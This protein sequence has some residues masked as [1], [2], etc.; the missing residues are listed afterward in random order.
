[1]AQEAASLIEPQHSKLSVAGADIDVPT[2]HVIER[3]WLR[4]RGRVSDLGNPLPW[5]RDVLSGSVALL[6]AFGIAYIT[7]L[8]IYAALGATNQLRFAWIGPLLLWGAIS[9]V[10]IA[11]LSYLMHSAVE[12]RLRANVG[13][14]L[15]EMDDIHAPPQRV[16]ALRMSRRE[17][18]VRKLFRAHEP[19]QSVTK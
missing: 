17:R 14:V 16:L 12:D 10:V 15:R 1:M 19:S 11:V 8:P 6:V 7:W 5:A 18:L 3:D 4:L 2:F 9:M 13:S